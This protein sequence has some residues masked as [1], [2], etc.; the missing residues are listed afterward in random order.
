ML[1][2]VGGGSRVRV[3]DFN[4]EDGVYRLELRDGDFYPDGP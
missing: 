2:T 3:V 1:G 4:V